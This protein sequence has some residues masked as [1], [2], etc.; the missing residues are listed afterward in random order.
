LCI[1]QLLDGFAFN[2]ETVVTT[3]TV[4]EISNGICNFSPTSTKGKWI[5]LMQTIIISFI[6]IGL[7]MIQNGVAFNDM[8]V[9]KQG[10]QEKD[11]MVR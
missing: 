6:P 11:R 1:F 2:N 7:L 3:I 4:Q 5:F 8:L 10:I 9:R